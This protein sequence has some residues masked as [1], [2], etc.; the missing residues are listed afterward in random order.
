[1]LYSL[2]PRRVKAGNSITKYNLGIA[3][4][5]KGRIMTNDTPLMFMMQI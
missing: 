1:M 4:F 5:F 2:A 3:Y